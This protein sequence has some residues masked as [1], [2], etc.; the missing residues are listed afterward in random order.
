[1]SLDLTGGLLVSLLLDDLK[2]VLARHPRFRENAG[3]TFAVFN[4]QIL[5]KD[6]SLSIGALRGDTTRLSPDY[7]VATKVGR[8]VAAH[9]DGKPGSFLEWLQ[10]TNT[11]PPP[12]MYYLEVEGIDEQTRQIRFIVAT[13]RTV[14]HTLPEAEGS[15][16]SV[17][18][19]I[20]IALVRPSDPL[21]EIERAGT[22]FWLKTFTPTLS[23]IR[24]DTNAV[25]VPGVDWW[26]ERRVTH[27]LLAQT[28]GGA[29]EV[30][31]PRPLTNIAVLDEDGNVLRAG[32]D[33]TFTPEGRIR[34]AN[35]TP[36]GKAYSVQ[37]TA[38]L[39]PTTTAPVHPENRVTIPITAPETLVTE[40]VVYWTSE[41]TF[42]VAD[43]VV[44]PDGERYLTTLLLPGNELRLEAQVAAPQV[45]AHAKKMEM[46]NT[47][48]PGVNLAL[49]DLVTVGDRACILVSDTEADTY[50]I[51]G[52]KDNVSLEIT[53]KSNDLATSSELASIVKRYL[54][55]EG[56]N[57][58]ESAGVSIFSAPFS[59]QGDGRDAS[60]TVVT[61]SV[62]LSVS[63][64]ADWEYYEPIVNRI[65][66]IDLDLFAVEALVS[67]YLEVGGRTAFTTSYY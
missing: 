48:V 61:H 23:L 2:P 49:G 26:I 65:T 18:L 36:A 40:S 50:R 30:D 33:W 67:P 8:V 47:L 17:A 32:R 44:A 34:L 42:T 10:E 39:D 35:W 5:Y 63:L 62:T 59:Y 53:I 51:Y 20:P 4:N 7:Y 31:L 12:G 16:V 57:R 41:G 15:G 6:V 3:E 21:I 66:A 11:P 52:G 54:L 19:D 38:L 56:R 25:L 45:F 9:V 37:G 58:L 13:Y 60:G 46:T 29:Q 55:I 14:E 43:T 1:M 64:A 22:K 28:L 24:T 27:P